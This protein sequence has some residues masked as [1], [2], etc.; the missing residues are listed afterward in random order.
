LLL[1]LGFLFFFDLLSLFV[2]KVTQIAGFAHAP[3]IQFS[4]SVLAL[5]GLLLPALTVVAISAE[6]L[7]V[8]S[9]VRVFTLCY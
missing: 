7:G 4:I 8:V 3:C 1:R 9:N 5:A 6:S 2:L